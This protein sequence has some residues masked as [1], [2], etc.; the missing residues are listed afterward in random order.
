MSA[1]VTT[2]FSEF[3]PYTFM[4][5]IGRHED[6]DQEGLALACKNASKRF[7]PATRG[8]LMIQKKMIA[9][10]IINDGLTR[11]HIAFIGINDFNAHTSFFLLY[12]TLMSLASDSSLDIRVYSLAPLTPCELREKLT[13]IL[14]RNIFFDLS[15]SRLLSTLRGILKAVF[16]KL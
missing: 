9:D 8:R 13:L 11:Q 6:F 3:E 2:G 12:S 1:A 7:E 16:T 5:F 4:S 15:Y 10:F 14:G